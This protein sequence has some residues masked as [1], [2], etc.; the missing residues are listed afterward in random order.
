MKRCEIDDKYKWDLSDIYKTR[1]ELRKDARRLPDYLEKIKSFKGR[2][3]E[4]SNSLSEFLKLTHEALCIIEK[5]EV[6]N[7]CIHDV[8][9]DNKLASSGLD[10]TNNM[11]ND[12]NQATAF[13]IPEIL[14][15][16]EEHVLNL[17]N[18]SDE[19]K[20]LKRYFKEIFKQKKHVLSENEEKIL[21]TFEV[22]IDGYSKT[23][24]YLIDKEIDYGSIT[25]DGKKVKLIASNISKYSK[26][27]DRE[28]RKRVYLKENAALKKFNDTLAN[29]YISFV[30]SLES[31]AKLR[32]FPD[33]LHQCF[34]EDDLDIEIYDNLKN[35]VKK[36]HD[37]YEMYVDIFKRT[38]KLDDVYI[39][40][41]NAPLFDNSKKEYTV[42]E[43]KEIILDTFKLFGP[44]YLEILNYAF[45]HGCI[46]YFP[47]ENKSTGWSSIYSVATLPKVFA[48]FEGKILDIS[49]LAHELGHFCNQYLS[50]KN[51]PF[52]Y[53]Y[54]STFCAEI[55]S[56]TNEIIFSNT[57]EAN[58][59][60]T[61]LQ[62]LFNFLKTFAN[63]FFGAARQ[64]VFEE[65]VHMK[66]ASKEALN[67]EI[68]NNIW[69]SS[70]KE[71]YGTS[72]KGASNY[73]WSTISHFYL[74][75]GYYVYNYAT[76]IIAATN[77]ASKIISNEEGF[78]DKYKK[79]LKLG[80]NMRPQD[81]LAV[82][83][84]DMCDPKTYD[85]AIDYFKDAIKKLNQFI[86]KR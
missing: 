9:L 84:I 37:A 79:F 76:A 53:V 25:V 67:S 24:S 50:I 16:S 54:H 62:L 21:S 63:N 28:V 31:I 52:E 55:A 69:E 66:A 58:D 45:D 29:N 59:E 30:K 32:N 57:Y 6:Y 38:L 12:Y 78:L 73:S 64:A 3:L 74:N 51:N 49:S 46:D 71:I 70:T 13:A 26:H 22:L 34:Y 86:E 56:L 82:L 23:H 75:N 60:D 17:I 80:S 39:Y 11:I 8:E 19:L 83:D 65:E 44:D 20:E 36:H 85:V 43:A 47:A 27:K 40:D 68:L 1:E 81:C 42:E 18:E 10:L 14:S 61:R 35:S 7:Y 2:I 4:S 72:L 33:Y 41:M 48:N 77:V 5:N 15:S